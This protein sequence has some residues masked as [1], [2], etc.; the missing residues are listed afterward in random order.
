VTQEFENPL[1]EPIEALYTF[2]LSER[3]AV[4]AMEMRT[5]G[6][7]I[8]GTIRRREEARRIYEAAKAAGQLAGLLDEERPNVFTQTVANL[9][10]GATVRVRIEYVEPLPF[11]DGR[12]EFS[13]PTVVGPRFVPPGVVDAA[14]I[15]PPVTP[16]GTRAGHDIS[17]R[18]DVDAGVP[19]E[20]VE[21]PLQ[22][23]DVRRD[24]SHRA[25]VPLRRGREIPNRDFVLRYRVAGEGVRSTH[26]LHRP[27]GEGDGYVT[28]VLV[29]PARVTAETAAPKEMIFV[30]DEALRPLFGRVAKAYLVGEAAEAFAATLGDT[31]HV[32]AGTV[33]AAATAALA[34]AEEG[35]VV[36]LA[37]ACASFDQFP[38]FEARGRAFEA[39]VRAH[40]ERG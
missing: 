31:P 1:D 16:K 37:P 10:P 13:F 5:D 27:D 28:F 9:M 17:I 14:R 11:A 24:G 32:I 36:L 15:T 40:I 8:R 2:P 18:V 30:I 21:S 4:D 23:I 3:A 34:D 20:A 29:P 33:E 26:L 7:T 6:R 35:E 19:I 12:F 38:D 39:A 22:Q 25:R